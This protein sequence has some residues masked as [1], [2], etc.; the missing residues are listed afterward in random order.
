MKFSMVGDIMLSRLVGR[1][2]LK[3]KYSVISDD[4]KNHLKKSDYV[5]GNLESPIYDSEKELDHLI[6]NASSS[7]LEEISFFNFLSLANNHIND[8]GDNGI[9]KTIESIKEFDSNGIFVEKYVPHIIRDKDFKLAIFTCTDM[10]NYQLNNKY[11]VCFIDDLFFLDLITEYREKGYLIL[12]YGHMGQLFSR[13]PNPKIRSICRKF[14]DAGADLVVTAHPH[15]LGGQE[16][17][18]GKNVFY[19]LGDFVM[20]GN[21][22]RRRRSTILDFEIKNGNFMNFNLLFTNT[23]IELQTVFSNIKTRNKS[24]KSWE[25]VSK[26]LNELKDLNKYL[27]IYKLLYKVE[28][29]IHSISTL[30]FIVKSK[31]FKYLFKM[32]IARKDEVFRTIKWSL[33]DRSSL[34]KDDD[35]IKSDRKINKSSELF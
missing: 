1:K 29:F 3:N 27:K 20:D 6:F 21:S 18:N 33:I 24:K 19:S 34:T 17:Y 12:V 32:L 31:G 5:I 2:Y 13:F 7:L 35:A 9:R 30:T 8:C 16:L 15:V 10:M 14:V 28:I 22:F 26:Y 4:V 11:K 25:K 23:N